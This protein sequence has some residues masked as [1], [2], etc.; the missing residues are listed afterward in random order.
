[1][2]DFYQSPR[3]TGEYNDCSVP[4]TFDQ[5]SN[6][7]YGCVY[8][9]SNYQRG[10]GNGRANYYGKKVKPVSVAHI[11]KLF[12][13]YIRQRI[14]MQWGGLSD[15]FCGFEKKLGVGLELLR[16]FREI[17]YPICFSTKG[18]LRWLW[19]NPKAG[20]SPYR[21][22]E[23]VMKPASKDSNGNLVYGLD[24]ARV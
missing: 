3:W 6:C 9:F 21:Q 17:D 16:F 4:L 1:M 22:F 12:T 13:E 18:Y 2:T 11:K 7:A 23:G 14:P 24:K 19:N 15:P 20:K 8:C 10:I 5:Y